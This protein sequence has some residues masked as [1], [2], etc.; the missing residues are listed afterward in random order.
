M[1]EFEAKTVEECLAQAKEELGTEDFKY[2]VLEETK[3]LFSKKA[4][5]GVYELSDVIEY[6]SNYVLTVV[7]SLGLNAT[8]KSSLSDDIIH[9]D[10]A[11][12]EDAPRIIGRGGE[13]LKAINELVRGATFNKFDKHYRILLNINNYKDQK[14]EK[15]IAMARRVAREV[16][17]TRVTA[18]LAPMTSDERRVVHNALSNDVHLKTVS[19][20]SGRERHITIQYVNYVPPK[21]V[22]EVVEEEAKEN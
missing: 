3:S 2:E 4:K 21:H 13:T 8:I 1:K 10:L 12:T 17:N 14:Y 16:K 20:G 5:I 9:L 19:V 15:L 7:E 22:E 6:A 11:S 18:S